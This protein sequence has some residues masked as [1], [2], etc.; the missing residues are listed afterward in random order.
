MQ[1]GWL[2]DVA[3]PASGLFW[4]VGE[5]GTILHSS[6]D[7]QSWKQQASPSAEDL[8]AVH[9]EDAK[10]GLAVGA[11]GAAVLTTDGGASWTS[12]ATGLDAYL[13]DVLWLDAKTALV[14]GEAGTVLELRR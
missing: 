14:V 2:N 8:Y 10:L 13:G 11:H 5:A 7:G 4:V 1:V 3:S 9:F 12:V 6:D